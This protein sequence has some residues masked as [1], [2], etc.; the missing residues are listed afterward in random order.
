MSYG[1]RAVLQARVLWEC[2]HFVAGVMLSG[3]LLFFLIGFLI[4][5][6]YEATTTLAPPDQFSIEQ[7]QITRFGPEFSG[8]L[9]MGI[10][11]SDTVQDEVINRFDLR[12][13]YWVNTYAKA[14]E[15]LS[16]HTTIQG[17]RRSGVLT[18]TVADHDPQ[19]AAALA[20]AYVAELNRSIVGLKTSSAHRERVFLEERLEAAKEELD[21]SAKR[22]GEFSSKNT[23]PD[24]EAQVS[25]SMKAL[26]KIEREVITTQ[27]ELHGL[28]QIYSPNHIRLRALQARSAELRWQK[29]HMMGSPGGD[30]LRSGPKEEVLP[31]LRQ[32][33]M[34]SRG[35]ADL[36]RDVMVSE[37]FFVTLSQLSELARVEETRN[38]PAVKVIDVAEPPQKS[39]GPPRLVIAMLG[40]IVAVSIAP[41]LLPPVT[42]LRGSG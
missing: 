10:L 22:L 25:A 5:T 38:I 20:Q 28:E 35:Y 37:A 36:H 3:T 40:T 11:R 15:K 27:A 39:S 24:I 34:L 7:P 31:P 1:A 12:R 19:R 33:P 18:I 29:E 16:D 9:V 2:R 21:H 13:I 30:A 41:I 14:R 26:A 4:P 17:D 23:A 42:Y 32:L 6:S 8:A